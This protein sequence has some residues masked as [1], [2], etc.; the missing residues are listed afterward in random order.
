MSFYY[1]ILAEIL[2]LMYL[3]EYHQRILYNLYFYSEEFFNLINPDIFI[4]INPEIE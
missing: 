3:N 4:N 2:M 1:I